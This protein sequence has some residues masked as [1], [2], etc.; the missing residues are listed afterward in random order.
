[1]SGARCTNA[2]KARAGGAAGDVCMK[3]STV[4]KATIFSCEPGD[5][6]KGT[7]AISEL[8]AAEPGISAQLAAVK[9]GGDTPIAPAVEGAA[10]QLRAYATAHPDHVAAL[11]LATDGSPGGCTGEDAALI[12]ARIAAARAGKPAL[13]TYAIGVVD[14]SDPTHRQAVSDFATAG[15]TGTPFFLDVNADLGQ[16]FLDALERIRSKALPCEFAD[17]QAHQ[18]GPRLH[19]GQRPLQQPRGRRR[20]LLRGQRRPLRSGEGRLVLRRSSR[21]RHAGARARLRR[22]LRPFQGGGRRQGRAAVR[23]P[24]ARHSVKKNR[25]A[26]RMRAASIV[27]TAEALALLTGR[28]HDDASS[29]SEPTP[30]PQPA[31]RP[32]PRPRKGPQRL[33]RQS[34]PAGWCLPGALLSFA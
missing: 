27:V 7:A 10:R 13:A 2:G 16:K 30:P 18:G 17:P 32:R 15:G 24:D 3:S 8:P 26:C 20:P 12:A 23:L 31:P 11:V 4:C 33:P 5:Y 1:M 19:Q 34:A 25:P 9:P 22:D 6:E 28:S 14:A 21:H 29:E